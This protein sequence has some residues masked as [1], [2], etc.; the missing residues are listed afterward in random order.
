MKKWYPEAD[1]VIEHAKIY[2]VA[3]TIE[4]IKAGKRDFPILEDGGIAAKDGKIIYVGPTEGVRSFVGNNTNVIDATG[5]IVTPGFVE[6]H[7]HA[8]WTGNNMRTVDFVGVTEREKA[9]KLLI[10]RVAQTALG[11][12]I[13]GNSWNELTW[14]VKEPFTAKEL[15]EIAPNNPVFCMRSC[16]HKA[17][18]NSA[19]MKIA[20]IDRNTPDPAGGKIGHYED[21]SPDGL[22]Y[23]NSAM[24]LV[25]SVIPP[26]TL[27]QKI[28]SIEGVGRMLNSMGFTSAM[29]CNLSFDQMRVYLEAKKRGKLSYRANLM[30]YL[31][32]AY[33]DRET[34]L[35]RLEE[36]D[37]V[38]GFGDNMLKLNGVKVTLDGIPAS[39]TSLMRRPYKT[40][41]DTYGSTVWS[42]E[43]ITAFV[44]KATELG[45]QF[46]IHT[47]GDATS[48]MALRAFKK[49]NDT[50]GPI[51]DLH[52][53]LIHYNFPHEDQYELMR[54][55]NIS[56]ALQ[57]TLVSTMGETAMYYEDQK[58]TVQSPGICFKN[59]IIAGGSSDSPVVTPDAVTGMYYAIT[60]LD[61]TSGEILSKGDESK[62]SPIEALIMYTKNSSYFMHDEDKLGSIEI[63]NLADLVIFDHDF[64]TGDI[65]GYR[66][67]HPEKTILGGEV[68]FER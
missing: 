33:G 9:R 24:D 65:E 56:A 64:I 42:E 39:Y 50:V 15:D 55:L 67:T 8:T 41:P 46:G 49:A 57:P 40:K 52:D 62:V 16:F 37:C 36:M 13:Q 19:A 29:D 14:D 3:I 23:E 18:V 61:E 60:R 32:S 10:D 12:W 6:S 66:T 47:I 45:W 25:Q 21:G 53:Y 22:L 44:C 11:E 17:M 31:D 43:D 20:G 59:G 63:G 34:H 7:M 1:L 26:L 68:V 5:K 48:D 38:T 54:E 35:R 2:T 58:Q 30:F 27:E 4:E 51:W 28:E